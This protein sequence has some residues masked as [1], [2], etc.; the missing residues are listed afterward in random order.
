LAILLAFYY[1]YYQ[2][3]PKDIFIYD[4]TYNVTNCTFAEQLSNL[5]KNIN[6]I[7]LKFE[8]LDEQHKR[9]IFSEIPNEVD[10]VL[11][12]WIHI[13]TNQYMLDVVY[14]NIIIHI[15]AELK[16]YKEINQQEYPISYMFIQYIENNLEA[17]LY[18]EMIDDISNEINK[19]L[20]DYRISSF[21]KEEIIKNLNNS[22]IPRFEK[23]YN[24][25]N[26][27]IVYL[28]TCHY[29]INEHITPENVMEYINNTWI[30]YNKYIFEDEKQI[31]KLFDTVTQF[32]QIFLSYDEKKIRKIL[33]KVMPI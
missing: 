8:Q 31:D 24:T 18:N 20:N 27:S 11:Q 32:K 15:Y 19:F 9:R 25:I 22:V 6:T 16:K 4:K 21:E 12:S 28:Y 5:V 13:F 10:N 29:L 23:V 2:H 1:Q 3:R 33:Y 26:E 30:T 14:R 7:Y 17:K